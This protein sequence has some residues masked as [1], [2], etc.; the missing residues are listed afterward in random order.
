MGSSYLTRPFIV[1]SN[2]NN[3][4]SDHQT[5]HKLQLN[6]FIIKS[7][8]GNDEVFSNPESPVSNTSDILKLK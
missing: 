6:G 3:L 5:T 4:I 2:I 7:A 8:T 1:S